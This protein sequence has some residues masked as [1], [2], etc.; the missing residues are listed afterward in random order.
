MSSR[1]LSV[2]VGLLA[3][4]VLGA[5][6]DIPLREREAATRDR[7]LQYAGAPID[8]F[9]WLGRYDSWTAIDKYQIVVWTNINDA[10]LITVEPPCE[11]L[12]FVRRI[13]LTQTA[14]TVNRRFDF[15]TT[16][17]VDSRASWKCMIKE[18][19][20]INYLKMK[21]DA[22]AAREAQKAQPQPKRE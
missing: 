18:I 21:Q 11:D 3:V 2:G 17:G 22:R 14:H 16:H 8:S 9:T 7:Y 6:S 13:G 15:V 1:L 10:Y 20:P 4:A 5:C 19:R 12:M